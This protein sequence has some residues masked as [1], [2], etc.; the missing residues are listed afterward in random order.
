MNRQHE[1]DDLARREFDV[2]VIGG[3]IAGASVAWLAARR[4]LAVGLIDAADFAS[5]ASSNSLKLVHGGLRY[6]K[7][8]LPREAL[9]AVRERREWMILAPHLIAPIPVVVPTYRRGLQNAA[10]VRMLL[11]ANDV[12]ARNR[13]RG[14]TAENHLPPARMLSRNDL[15]ELAPVLADADIAGGAVFYDAQIRN[16]ER[17][18]VDTVRAATDA[19]ATALNYVELV[20]GIIR[21]NKVVGAR[22]AD[23]VGNAE[24]E[25]RTRSVVNAAGGQA[26][27]VMARLLC[28]REA[29]APRYSVAM[30]LMIPARGMK[31]ALAFSSIE[32][33]SGKRRQLLWVPW[34]DREI[35]GT[36]HWPLPPDRATPDVEERHIAGFIA[37]V[38]RALTAARVDPQDVMLVHA[39]LLPM[40]RT[41]M[42]GDVPL[43][44]RHRVVDHRSDGAAGAVS[45]I[46]VKY[47]TSRL[48]A[49]EA[50]DVVLATLGRPPAG[51][52]PP[53][54]L[55]A[56]PASLT[57][58]LESARL[59]HGLELEAD[60][61]DHLVHTYGT[62]YRDVLAQANGDGRLFERVAP[63]SPVIHAELLHGVRDELAVSADDLLWRR[64]EIA[65][66]GSADPTA[67]A[68]ARTV[69]ERELGAPR[70]DLVDARPPLLGRAQDRGR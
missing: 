43:L 20:R 38:R 11:A 19:G 29:F 64:T 58:E 8:L 13:N 45:V 61:L 70:T 66:R 17:L 69:I 6:L 35:L 27:A 46:T 59:S 50:L 23:R 36:Y 2:L 49:A 65:T 63:D 31:A 67:W 14:V 48:A 7:R 39:G 34:R 1:L 54:R 56:A 25:I 55:P 18:V 30:N 3:G 68:R 62:H 47:T 44:R 52:E 33:A 42:R 28:A 51:R 21:H 37:E 60:V 26:P 32:E 22:L 9:E 53:T 16:T 5:G 57:A 4:G 10:F 41:D 24:F 40:S 15:V 12:F